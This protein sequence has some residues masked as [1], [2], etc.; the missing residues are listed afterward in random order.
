MG[1]SFQERIIREARRQGL[2]GYA[3]AKLVKGKVSMR[4]V[5]HYLSGKRDM[6]GASVEVLARALGL[7]L[8]RSARRRKSR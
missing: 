6:M 5:Q 1:I 2:S 3:L 4:M 7:E 8:R